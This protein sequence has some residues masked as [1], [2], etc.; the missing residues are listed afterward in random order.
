MRLSNCSHLTELFAYRASYAI[1]GRLA[2][3]LLRIRR[4][5]LVSLNSLRNYRRS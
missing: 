3:L 1:W 4:P 2:P 5:A